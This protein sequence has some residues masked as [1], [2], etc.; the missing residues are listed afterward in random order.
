LTTLQRD[1]RK[2]YLI[3]VRH[4]GKVLAKIEKLPKK[5]K[6]VRN[7]GALPG[8]KRGDGANAEIEVAPLIAIAVQGKQIESHTRQKKN[9]DGD[10]FS[11]G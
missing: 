1:E 3:I 8:D 4:T 5:A 6:N 9:G 11:H 10:N 2:A 7:Y